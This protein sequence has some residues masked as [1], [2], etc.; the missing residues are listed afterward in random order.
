MNFKY[1][2]GEEVRT[3]DSVAYHGEPGR[4][5]FVADKIA[6]D[7]A[8]DWYVEEFG[9]G[10]MIVAEEFGAVFITQGCR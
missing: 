3:G 2:S 9:G 10:F 4:V 8:T 7:P 1:L 6:G 5:E